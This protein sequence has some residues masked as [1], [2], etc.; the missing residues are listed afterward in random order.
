MEDPELSQLT[1]WGQIGTYKWD[2]NLATLIGKAGRPLSPSEQLAMTKV[3]EQASYASYRDLDDKW[4]RI[5]KTGEAIDESKM[6][7]LLES[8]ITKELSKN[9]IT[10][11]DLIKDRPDY[12]ANVLKIMA[13]LNTKSNVKTPLVIYTVMAMQEKQALKMAKE[14]L[15]KKTGEKSSYDWKDYTSIDE[16]DLAKIRRDILLKNQ[17]LLNLDNSIVGSI[18]EQHIRK[19][20]NNVF[21]KFDDVSNLKGIEDEVI[22]LVRTQYLVS[23]IIKTEKD[24]TSVTK[25][26]SR[27]ATALKWLNV[28]TPA[29]VD[30]ALQFLN[31]IQNN[32]MIDNKVKLSHQAAV[33]YGLNKSQYN[34][35]KDNDKFQEL[36]QDSQKQLTNWMYKVSSDTL[37]YDSKSYIAGINK[38]ATS[39]E[40]TKKF[41]PN[42]KSK[43]MS[44][45]RPW[46]SD[47]FQPVRD[48]LP[49][50]QQYITKDPTDYLQRIAEAAPQGFQ[51]NNLKFPIMQ[52]YTRLLIE[53]TYYGYKSKGIV[54]SY[55]VEPKIDVKQK[56]YI[57]LK[58][59]AK[60][61]G[62]QKGWA[63]KSFP[64]KVSGWAW[65]W[66]PG[67]NIQ[68]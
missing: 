63:K 32:P 56:K 28:G 47:Q 49:G 54:P 12:A 38:A 42:F 18:I 10:M 51:I 11:E 17:E 8:Q 35:L 41:Y 57:N 1:R 65:A 36:T 64:K 9:G 31:D 34:I 45:Q 7:D 21:Q 3:W 27:Y 29:G 52:E 60:A 15:W 55:V 37:D 13:V 5:K 58:K 6:Q 30:V 44:G 43:A 61:Q 24:T 4:N 19:N 66:L 68:D 46:F 33:L 25:L 48:F 50:K 14:T 23:N 59:P 2:Y 67:S 62:K 39:S 26:Q 40:A 16:S 22:N 20:H 53:N